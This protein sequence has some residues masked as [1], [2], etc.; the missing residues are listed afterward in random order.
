M[1]DPNCIIAQATIKIDRRQNIL[2][3]ISGNKFY[4]G[5]IFLGEAISARNMDMLNKARQ[6]LANRFKDT[7]G[8]KEILESAGAAVI[9]SPS[10]STTD[11][12]YKIDI[13]LSPENIDK[14][15]IMNLIKAK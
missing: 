12:K 7:I 3:L 15:S 11:V 5:N 1:V 14:N 2:G 8:L 10:T 9:Q 4:F 13:D 6:Y